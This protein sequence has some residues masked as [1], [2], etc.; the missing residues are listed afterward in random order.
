M[1]G[2]G[3]GGAKRRGVPCRQ[4]V[5]LGDAALKART[6]A[7]AQRSGLVHAAAKP[8]GFIEVSAAHLLAPVPASSLVI[9]YVAREGGPADTHRAC[10]QRLRPP[11]AGGRA[12]GL[13]IQVTPQMRV[14][15]AIEPVDFRRGVDGLAQQCRAAL[16]EAPSAGRCSS[17]ATASA[18]R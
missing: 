17:S 3:L 8:D 12:A 5:G 13:M 9:E 4:P 15:V 2:C 16:A 1:E 10:L 7:V 6:L 18:P 14:L 11:R